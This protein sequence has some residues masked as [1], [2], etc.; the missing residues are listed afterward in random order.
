MV[1][2]DVVCQRQGHTGIVLLIVTVA[3]IANN[4]NHDV[5][6]P[7]AKH[8]RTTAGRVRNLIQPWHVAF[9]TIDNTCMHVAPVAVALEDLMPAINCR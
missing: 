4:V 2:D 9:Q 3:P 7:P 5:L 1:F 8:P 6:V